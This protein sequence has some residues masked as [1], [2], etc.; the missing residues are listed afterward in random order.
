MEM[1]VVGLKVASKKDAQ[2]AYKALDAKQD[3]GETDYYEVVGMW[4]SE[5]GKV[6]AKYYGNHDRLIGT[7]VGALFGAIPA[8]I[9]YYVG[10]HEMPKGK[11]S[12]RFFDGLSAFVD[13]GG[14]AIFALVEEPDAEPLAAFFR[15]TYPGNETELIDPAAFEA[16]VA[17][18]T[19]E[20]TAAEA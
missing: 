8:V 10:K 5:S 2:H 6:H 15:E 11:I 9:G 7:A 12:T 16:D 4:K 3:A 17:V 1:R 14:A 18:L 20:I 13:D 19:E